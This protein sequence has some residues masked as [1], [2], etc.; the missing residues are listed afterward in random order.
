MVTLKQGCAQAIKWFLKENRIPAGIRIELLFT[1]CC[2]PSLGLR[3]DDPNASDLVF[4]LE[5]FT[6]IMSSDTYE[7][8]GEITID[9]VD[10]GIQKGFLLTSSKPVSEW[11]GFA[12]CNISRNSMPGDKI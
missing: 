3:M 8:T 4:E 6:F 7:T 5:D 11:Q 10:D 9:Y 2:D 12:P 1:G